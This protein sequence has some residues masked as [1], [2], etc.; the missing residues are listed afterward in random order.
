MK[1]LAVLPPEQLTTM[2]KPRP[3]FVIINSPVLVIPKYVLQE[4]AALCLNP[5]TGT[6][7]TAPE[8]QE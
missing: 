8:M 3:S 7:L 5:S 2:D 6:P 1:R 4:L